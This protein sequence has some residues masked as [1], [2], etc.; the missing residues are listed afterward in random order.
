[1]PTLAGVHLWMFRA[2]FFGTIVGLLATSA[3]YYI[4][5]RKS[6]AERYSGY[7]TSGEKTWIVYPAV[8]ANA[9]FEFLF[10]KRIFSVRSVSVLLT[11]SVIANLACILIAFAEFP[12]DFP[13]IKPEII[14]IYFYSSLCFVIFN[15]VGDFVS[16]SI[17]RY[18]VRKIVAR[19]HDLFKYLLTDFGGI[20]LG[21]LITLMPSYGLGIYCIL[22][23]TDLNLWITKGFLGSTIIPFFYYLLAF[24]GLPP[25]FG[26]WAA[27]SVF[28]ITIPTGIYLILFL[29]CLVGFQIHERWWKDRSK[30]RLEIF[31][32]GLGTFIFKVLLQIAAAILAGATLIKAYGHL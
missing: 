17:T 23:S 12:D 16:L 10:G 5:N 20:L 15:F 25:I 9:F 8:G 14:R 3:H 21:Y 11:I 13:P 30:D 27:V 28:S 4:R 24:G 31:F 2:I 19:E 26:I 29:I 6:L 1:M 32:K 22:T 7:L 18:C